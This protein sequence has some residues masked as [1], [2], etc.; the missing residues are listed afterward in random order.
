[1]EEN[2]TTSSRG[3]IPSVEQ[4][5]SI[6]ICREVWNEFYSWATNHCNDILGSLSLPVPENPEVSMNK[7]LTI[8]DDFSGDIE[9]EFELLAVR[10]G[11]ETFVIEEFDQA[12]NPT[13]YSTLR[14]E[15]GYC[16]PN[17]I[18][19]K[20]SPPYEFCT[21]TS[22][23]YVLTDP[24]AKSLAFLPYADDP[25]FSFEEY[26]NYFESLAWQ[27]DFFDPDMELIL[28]EAATR[29]YFD[30]SY[31]LLDI[32]QTGLFPLR[33]HRSSG[34][35]WETAQRDIPWWTGIGDKPR[36]QDA[37]MLTSSD[38]LENLDRDLPHFCP[39][40]GCLRFFCPAHTKSY[41]GFDESDEKKPKLT[42]PQLQVKCSE[43]CG[44]F[45]YKND[46]YSM[47]SP[48]L[49]N[50]IDPDGFTENLLKIIPDEM[51]CDLAII[52]RK[53]CNEDTL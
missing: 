45:C 47:V 14:A 36:L 6:S 42:G 2:E 3:E 37:Q 12:E 29:L 20:A 22:Q 16:D 11:S 25:T 43:A 4:E 8:V 9:F 49:E 28:L 15:E 31:S 52:C 5:F 50:E 21:S 46:E 53:R 19:F 24:H 10:E 41:P 48:K 1:M 7:Q 38:L 17:E 33:N 27:T 40:F 18:S 23:N 13:R 39:L 26:L 51:P 32:E 44:D 34:L 35:L 30:H